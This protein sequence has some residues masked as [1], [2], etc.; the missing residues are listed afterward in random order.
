LEIGDAAY[1]LKF[2][3]NRVTKS[4]VLHVEPG[5]PEATL[6]A[7]LETGED[8]PQGTFDCIILTQTLSCI[9]HADAAVRNCYSALK[10]HGVVLATFPGI[11]QI[12]RYDMDRWGEF[13]RFTSLS[14]KRLFQLAFPA[15]KLQ[16]RTYGNVLT[17]AAALYGFAAEELEEQELDYPDMDYEVIV[18]VRAQREEG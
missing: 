2:G 13:W 15:D 17:A 5:N 12:S 7:N 9:F 6:V 3:G 14:A 1:T 11:A 10:P 4:D 16:V 18:A 8:L